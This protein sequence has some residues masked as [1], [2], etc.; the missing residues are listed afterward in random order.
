MRKLFLEVVTPER[1]VYSG[2]VD[3]V[4]ANTVEG[5]IGILPLHMPL[6]SLLKIGELRVKIGEET[7]Y[8]AVHGGYLEVKEDK[9]SVLAEAAELASEIDVARARAAKERAEEALKGESE[10]DLEEAQRA[11]ERALV[12][13]R[14]S[15]KAGKKSLSS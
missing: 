5:E 13:L 9:V 10:E 14:I 3:M 6:I 2:E 12:R 11:L 8:I 1:I 15:D 7:E 4:I